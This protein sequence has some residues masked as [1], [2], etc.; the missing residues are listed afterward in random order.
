MRRTLFGILI[1]ITAS[2]LVVIAASFRFF[3]GWRWQIGDMLYT[4]GETRAPV[5]II[6][7][8]RESLELYGDPKNWTA[9]RYR[10]LFQRLGEM[11]AQVIALDFLPPPVVEIALSE[12]RSNG[13]LVIMPVLGAGSSSSQS[14]RLLFPY[15]FNPTSGANP[16]GHINLH[17]DP[18][19]VLRRVPLW[20]EGSGKVVPA[21]SWRAA[22]VYLHK[23][24]PPPVNSPFTWAGFSI[25]PDASG[26]VQFR[27]PVRS[28]S[29]PVYSLRALLENELP[30]GALAGQVVFVG[31][32]EGEGAEKYRTP[33]G[34]MS[35]VEVQAQITIAWLT[36]QMLVPAPPHF[37]VLLTLAAA[38]PSSWAIARIRSRL[39]IFITLLAIVGFVLV[40]LLLASANGWTVEPF[41]PL[42][43]LLI[44]V[45]A[46]AIWR[47]YDKYREQ[48]RLTRLLRG[49]ISPK[50]VK[51]LEEMP[52]GEQ[53]LNAD[54]RFVVAL[55]ADVRGFVRLTEGQDPRMVQ[56]A[57]NLHLSLFTD[58]V[59]EAGGMVTKYVGDMIAAIFNAP[60]P[61]DRP[62][63]QALRA[64]Q[65][66]QQRL[67][68]LWQERPD[69]LRLPMGVGIH[70][71]AAVVGLLGSSSHQEYDAIGDT[72][73]VAARLSNYAPAGEIYVT[74]AVVAAAGKEWAFEPLGVM[75]VRGR[76]EP[77]VAYRLKGKNERT[78][79]PISR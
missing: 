61:I 46:A 45:V 59:I 76:Y 51:H 38:L 66:G 41:F 17:P 15:L 68:R 67:R 57:A 37:T 7:I 8:D 71:G 16:V 47:P 33:I 62:V 2:L 50:L 29:I 77:I 60:L 40:T 39:L 9:D 32:T 28:G 69:L 58:A 44:A 78:A 25:V 72:V 27:Y 19:G 14:G 30:S 49:R 52:S 5:V 79:Y 31:I 74:E 13:S 36:G 53:L 6:A 26:Y 35:G 56:E 3:S 23:A 22:A 18:D 73:N 24:V 54:V 75:Q 63:D 34:E 64:A 21:L 65:E 42:M 43:G 12:T 48:Q 55:F 4:P 70:A 1:G 11:R 10:M 20:I